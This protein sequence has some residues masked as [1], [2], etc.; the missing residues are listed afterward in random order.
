MSEK[1]N[2]NIYQKLIEVRKAVPY[3][4]KDEKG[5]EFMFVSSS[6]VLGTLKAKMDSLGLLLIPKMI[7]NKV[8]DHQTK[9]GGHNYFTEIAM[10]YTWINADNPEESI[11]CP[12]YG[13]GLDAGEKGVG[14]AYTYAEKY[15]LLKFFNIPTDKDDPDVFRNKVGS[16]VV[17]EPE[18]IQGGQVKLINDL[19]KDTGADEVKFATYLLNTYKSAK[20]EELNTEDAKQ[21]ILTL[22]AK[23]EYVEK[24]KAE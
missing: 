14:K 18:P 4:K 2:M 19:I 5:Y 15:F 23:L 7:N 12:W 24:E 22:K 3:L 9:K 17:V 11:E 1:D 20:V 16:K 10:T 8:S 21:V 13:Q 6:Q